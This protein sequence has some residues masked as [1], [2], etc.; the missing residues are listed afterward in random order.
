MGPEGRGGSVRWP[1]RIPH[2]L[3]GFRV[4]ALDWVSLDG[5]QWEVD[6]LGHPDGHWGFRIGDVP[7]SEMVA[8]DWPS[9]GGR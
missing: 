7:S 3:D 4:S 1:V 8:T 9:A 5:G 6:S 2:D